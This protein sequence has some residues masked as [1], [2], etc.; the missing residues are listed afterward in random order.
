MEQRQINQFSDL[1]HNID[2]QLQKG[3]NELQNQIKNCNTLEK[4]ISIIHN[5]NLKNENI[6]CMIINGILNGMLFDENM[7]LDNYFN[8]LY[9][10]NLDSFKQFIK[11]LLNLLD[12]SKL[13]KDKYDKIYQIFEKLTKYNINKYDL[14]KIIILICRNFY[15]GQELISSLI[16][17]IDNNNLININND[18]NQ[19]INPNNEEN[20]TNNY[21]YKFLIFIKSNL[22]FIFENGKEYNLPGIIFIKILRLLSETHIYHHIYKLSN[23]DNPND[24]H[25]LADNLNQIADTYQKI[26]FNEKTKK[27]I[28]EIYDLQIYILTKIYKEKKDNI[29]DIGRELIR[30]LIPLGNSNIEIIKIIF[31]DLLKDNYYD[32]I[33]SLPYNETGCNLYAQI[34][35]PPSMERMLI[36]LLTNVKRSSNTYS[37]YLNWILKEFHIENCI[38]KSIIVD[39]ARFIMTNYCFYFRNNHISDCIPRWLILSYILKKTTNLILSSEIKQDLFFDLI[40]FD[41]ERD[42]LFLIEPSIQSIMVN[43]KDFPEISEELIEFLDSYSKHFDYNNPQKRINSVIEGFKLLEEKG[44]IINV[45]KTINESK[46]ENKFKTILLNYLRN[47]TFINSN[48]KINNNNSNSIISVQNNNYNQINL[49]NINNIKDRGINIYENKTINNNIAQQLFNNSDNN[50]SNTSNIS[51][52]QQNDNNIKS[53]NKIDK[54]ISNEKKEIHMEI[55]ISNI[56]VQNQILQKFLSEKTKKNFK[57]VLND[58]CNYNIKMFD[59]LDNGLKMNDSSYNSLCNNF[60]NFYIEI[61]KDEFKD[62]K[63]L[64]IS[65]N[66]VDKFKQ[67]IYSYIFD[68]AYENKEDIKKF[69]F[70]SD[71]I[72]KIIEIYQPFI[73]HLMEYVLYYTINKVKKKTKENYNGIIFFNQ[74]NNNDIFLKKNKLELFFTQCENNFLI[75]FMRDFFKCGGV[76]HFKELFFDD[77]QMLY[78]IIKNCDLNCINTINIS[79]MNNKF[80]IIDKNFKNL[81]RLSLLL[82][83]SEKNIF[84]NLV[85]SQ[86]FIPSL[87]LQDFLVY[88]IE[89]LKNPPSNNSFK[90][91]AKI[92]P[93]EFFGKIINS[94]LIIFQKEIY[95]DIIEESGWDKLISKC[96]CIFDF[97]ISF[98]NYIYQIIDSLLNNYLMNDK[99]KKKLFYYMVEQYYKN[100]ISNI[101]NLRALAELLM[102]NETSNVGNPGNRIDNQNSYCW[103]SDKIKTL[104]VE[105][106]K[107]ISLLS[108]S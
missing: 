70:I 100:N 57:E 31:A 3:S 59:K 37:Y 97:G 24:L 89:L 73:L 105:I 32:K 34:N 58:I 87:N 28:G 17:N 33:L 69:S 1:S 10:I 103:L 14:I 42:D 79:L 104:K 64:Y 19:N 5:L 43:M 38:G 102:I 86:R 54:Q 18:Q 21:F 45:E 74:I 66:E 23:D 4:K 75:N 13:S 72:N 39:I 96:I 53:N 62:F 52:N 90:E 40:L 91:V 51:L 81:Y 27:V 46:I 44:Y 78:K 65:P 47:P 82:S 84:W 107:K 61:F 94:I 25:N 92:D 83:P 30:H 48:N 71:L 76:E 15:P 41:K 16:N 106:I 68:Y 63:N 108:S 67:C 95:T 77:E 26:G 22:D 12:F 55:L 56:C 9:S 101:N 7:S 85:F 35:I 88:S 11:T 20:S 2:I 50:I 98:K 29:F 6:Y 80:I 60:A 93:D 49:N 8:M 99:D 36:Y